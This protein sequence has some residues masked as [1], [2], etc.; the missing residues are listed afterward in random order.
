MYPSLA[1]NKRK[2]RK[3][4]WSLFGFQEKTTAVLNSLT[5]KGFVANI[6]QKRSLCWNSSET[7]MVQRLDGHLSW[8]LKQQIT[9]FT[10]GGYENLLKHSNVNTRKCDLAS[11]KKKRNVVKIDK[12]LC[13]EHLPVCKICFSNGSESS[14]WRTILKTVFYSMIALNCFFPDILILYTVRW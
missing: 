14:L 8:N 10:K 6:F 5:R 2:G 9:Y 12:Y 3:E 11:K 4:N 7:K 1:N 13:L